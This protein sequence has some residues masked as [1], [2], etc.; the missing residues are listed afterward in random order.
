MILACVLAAVAV[1]VVLGLRWRLSPLTAYD[2][3]CSRLDV[4]LDAE[5]VARTAEVA[6]MAYAEKV[7]ASV[8]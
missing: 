2:V 8:A 5:A 6:K 7:G 3:Q 1:I 4:A